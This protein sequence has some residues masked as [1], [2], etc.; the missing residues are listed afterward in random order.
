MKTIELI[1]GIPCLVS[2]HGEILQ[3]PF[4]KTPYNHDRNR[5]SDES[6]LL[7]LD[8]SLTDQSFKDDA[9]INIVV[10]RFLKTGQLPVPIPEQ[11][12]DA[13]GKPSTWL[14]IQ[15]T[16]ADNNATFYRLA[17]EIRAEFLNNPALWMDQLEKDVLAGDIDNLERLGMETGDLKAARAKREQEAADAAIA[18]EAADQAAFEKRAQRASGGSPAQQPA[19]PAGGGNPP[20]KP[21]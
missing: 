1:A 21:A 2:E 7:C 13:I 9:D 19:K 8:E 5:D 3:Q 14:E 11:F 18:Q 16:L 6:A 20:P 15:Q 12:G 4:F 10:E 17:P